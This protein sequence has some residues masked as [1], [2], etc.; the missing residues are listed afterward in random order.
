MTDTLAL[1]VSLHFDE[2]TS[3]KEYHAVLFDRFVATRYGRRHMPGQGSVETFDTPAKAAAKYWNIL[4]NKT[5]KGY[6]V[7][8][9]LTIDLAAATHLLLGGS[10]P[11]N[12]RDMD[13]MIERWIRATEG[14]LRAG[15]ASPQEMPDWADRHPSP[16]T[17]KQGSQVILTMTDPQAPADALFEAALATLEERFLW[18]LAISHPNCPDEAKVARALLA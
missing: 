15:K 5:G 10:T 16:R 1:A 14:R 8:D 12:R 18:N 17:G 13:L 6:A 11:T 2:G 3:D 4:R 7:V 9:A